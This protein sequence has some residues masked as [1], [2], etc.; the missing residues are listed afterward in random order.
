ESL[1]DLGDLILG[2]LIAG[3]ILQELETIIARSAFSINNAWL[4][5][6]LLTL[7]V[8]K[9]IQRHLVN[10]GF[11]FA[12][13]KKNTCN[14]T[15]SLNRLVV[16]ANISVFGQGFLAAIQNTFFEIIPS[17]IFIRTNSQQMLESIERNFAAA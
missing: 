10:I 12:D 9:F 13:R 4:V 6:K 17:R 15:A 8:D 7:E 2:K 3:G 1:E 14:F 11:V 16:K 5:T